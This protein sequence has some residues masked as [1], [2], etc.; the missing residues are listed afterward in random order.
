MIT[1]SYYDGKG[2][3]RA[4]VE[5]DKRDALHAAGFSNA[6]AIL[7]TLHQAGWA[8]VPKAALGRIPETTE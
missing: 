6:D 3:A 2:L 8:I 1:V 5:I 4:E 7:N